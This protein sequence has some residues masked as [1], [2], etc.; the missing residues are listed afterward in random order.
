MIRHVLRVIALASL[1]VATLAGATVA[2]AH[3]DHTERGHADIFDVSC[4]GETL[5]VVVRGVRGG[6]NGGGGASPAQVLVGDAKTI[7]PV[8]F[9]FRAIQVSTGAVLFEESD[10]IGKGKRT[11]QQERLVTCRL[12]E[13]FRDPDLGLLRFEVIVTAMLTPQGK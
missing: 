3:D 5:T 4:N 8:I 7:V 1:F 9:S 6:E 11:G 2:R 10:S 12:S 13:T